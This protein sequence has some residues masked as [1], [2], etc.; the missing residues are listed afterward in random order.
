VSAERPLT[1]LCIATYEKGQEFL[2]ECKRQGCRVLLLTLDTLEHADWPR[3][4]I[5]QM[6]YL[7][8]GTPLD[9]IVKGVSWMARTEVIDRIVALDDFDVET[10]AFLREHLRVPGMGDSTARYFRDKLAMRVK[11]HDH[12]IRVPP[13]AH[14]LN[15]DALRAFMARV[16][17]PWVLKPRSE[18]SAVG[19]RKIERADDLWPALDTLGDRQ[20]FY[21]LEKYVPGDVYHVDAIVWDREPVFVVSHKYGQPPMDVAHGGGIFMT[22]RLHRDA[23]ERPALEALTGKLLATLGFVRGVT[24]TEFI[25]DREDAEFYFLETAARVGGAHITDVV[26]AATGV[27]LWA[28]WARLEIAG[29]GGRYRVA[30]ARDDYAGIVLSLARDDRP[31][32]SSFN[33]PE[34]WYRVARSHHIGFVVASPDYDR[35]EHLLADYSRRIAA[36][37]LATAP[38]PDKPTA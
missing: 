20:S 16:P 24:H 34:I 17:G 29:E 8:K 37:H 3:E 33:D 6:F 18:A 25:R 9:D 19:I 5:D 36:D 32:T 21:V 28:E 1:V 23:P 4:S 14:V 27:N 13:F 22:R 11:A 35:V 30:P 12:G 26:E 10:A 31:D 38:V 7:R 15:Y 2:R